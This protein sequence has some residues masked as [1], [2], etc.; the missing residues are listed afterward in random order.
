MKANE[1]F[2]KSINQ[3]CFCRNDQMSAVFMDP[4]IKVLSVEHNYH[5]KTKDLH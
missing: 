3:D 2:T 5:I 1:I 4:S